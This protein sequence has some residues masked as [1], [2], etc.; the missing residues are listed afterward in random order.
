MEE[1]P[2][3]QIPSVLVYIQ[4]LTGVKQMID[5]EFDLYLWHQCPVNGRSNNGWLR[6]MFFNLTQQIIRQD[7]GHWL[8]YV[9]ARPDHRPQLIS[10]SYYAKFVFEK[11]NSTGFKHVDLNI[12]AFL[13]TGRGGNAIQGSV[14]LDD[15]SEEAGCTQLVKGFHRH[16][17]R[18]K[19]DDEDGSGSSGTIPSCRPDCPLRV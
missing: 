10:F 17:M 9:A 14:S 18:T 6:N 2:C 7:L 3:L 5:D 8:L 13:G 1:R 12:D 19:R 16:I 4:W 15:E 11:D